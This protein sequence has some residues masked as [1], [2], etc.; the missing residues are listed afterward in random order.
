MDNLTQEQRRKNMKAIRSSGTKIELLLGKGLWKRGWRYRKNSS[1][2]IG[3]PDFSFKSLK[4]AIFVDSEFWHGK[5][6]NPDRF[7]KIWKKNETS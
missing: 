5:E 7:L 4:V 1:N 6:W 2:I 3:K